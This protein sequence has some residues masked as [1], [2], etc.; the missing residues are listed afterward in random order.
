MSK[1]YKI[2]QVIHFSGFDYDRIVGQLNNF[3]PTAN[4]F[5][6]ECEML[7]KRKLTTKDFISTV[8]M[9]YGTEAIRREYVQVLKK[10]LTGLAGELLADSLQQSVSKTIAKLEQ[11]RVALMN[12]YNQCLGGF[13]SAMNIHDVYLVDGVATFDAEKIR[14]RFTTKIMNK[15]Q[16]NILNKLA[17]LKILWDEVNDDINSSGCRVP[18][19]S[20]NGGGFVE[21]D[22]DGAMILDPQAIGVIK[23]SVLVAPMA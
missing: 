5:I 10:E 4:A 19:F 1:D 20:D 18:M 9:S 12:S 3:L 16:L 7:I 8:T 23:D 2:D 17:A 13:F 22:R 6:Q 15:K 11:K 14:S 21:I